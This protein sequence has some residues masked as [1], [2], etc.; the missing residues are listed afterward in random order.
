MS[1]PFTQLC[2]LGCPP[3]SVLLFSRFS[4]SLGSPVLSVLSVLSVLLFSQFSQFCH[5]ISSLSSLSSPVLSLHACIIN[6]HELY[7]MF[8]LQPQEMKP[9]TGLKQ[10]EEEDDRYISVS[11]LNITFHFHCGSFYLCLAHG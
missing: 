7:S 8:Y 9:G 10:E 6:M 3:F 1:S 5:P 2:S 11:T 4:C